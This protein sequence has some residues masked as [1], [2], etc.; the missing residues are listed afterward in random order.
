MLHWTAWF[1]RAEDG[2]GSDDRGTDWCL[3]AETGDTHAE[4]VGSKEEP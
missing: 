2:D 1:F 4:G 3:A